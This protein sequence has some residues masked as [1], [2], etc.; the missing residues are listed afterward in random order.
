MPT[1]DSFIALGAGNGFPFCPTKVDVTEVDSGGNDVREMW[2]TID[3]YNK[4]TTNARTAAGIAESRRLAR[5]YVWN[6]YE[7]I[8]LASA[9]STSIT[10]ANSEDHGPNG[11][12]FPPKD[13][14]CL[15]NKGIENE[16]DFYNND[17]F[18]IAKLL[19]D[20]HLSITAMYEGSTSNESNFIGYGI[21][22]DNLGG[23]KS[24]VLDITLLDYAFVELKWF[25]LESEV[26]C[27]TD[28]G[29]T[30]CNV[31]RNSQY[32]SLSMGGETFHGVGVAE[33]MNLFAPGSPSVN[34]SALSVSSFIT[35]FVDDFSISASLSSL[36]AYTY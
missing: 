3:G 17:G 1:A 18:Q 30:Y 23:I 10:S 20:S 36:T 12:S 5:L 8:G 4:D 11:G 21:G 31:K 33:A 13:R 15:G 9:S 24:E 27:Y 16:D 7:I 14:V 35:D 34:G 32:T 28:G 29:D 25:G 19:I 6:L 2:S 26:D 22:T